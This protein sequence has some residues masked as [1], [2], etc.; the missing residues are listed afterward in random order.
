MHRNKHN[1]K[2]I[3]RKNACQKYHVIKKFQIASFPVTLITDIYSETN[4][5]NM[6]LFKK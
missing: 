6:L 4:Y 2:L 5:K 1:A 3:G